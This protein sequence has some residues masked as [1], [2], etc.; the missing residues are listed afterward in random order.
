MNFELLKNAHKWIHRVEKKFNIKLKFKTGRKYI[1]ILSEHGGVYCFID[2]NGDVLKAASW[3][4][5]AK[6]ARGNIFEV[7]KEGVD[8]YGAHYLV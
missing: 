1:K 2:A 5:P 8:K 4:A 6:H 7:G 3:N